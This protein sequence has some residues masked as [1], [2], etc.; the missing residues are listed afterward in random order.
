MMVK[1]ETGRGLRRDGAL[2]A[3]YELLALGHVLLRERELL[4]SY[5]DAAR[6][7]AGA[8]R[9]RALVQA[10]RRTDLPPFGLRPP[11]R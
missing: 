10:R 4:G 9:R 6:L 7:L 1:N 8:R 3:V 2:I 5:R 11:D